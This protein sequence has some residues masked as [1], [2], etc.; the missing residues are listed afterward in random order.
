[1]TRGKRAASLAHHPVTS[2]RNIEGCSC[3]GVRLPG[4][5]PAASLVG[6]ISDD[7]LI[8]R[9]GR[10][11][12]IHLG[13][14]WH[15]VSAAGVVCVLVRPW[16]AR[17]DSATPCRRPLYAR[18][19]GGGT[20]DR[21]AAYQQLFAAQTC[22][23]SASLHRSGLARP[24]SGLGHRRAGKEIM[25]IRHLHGLVALKCSFQV[26][27]ACCQSRNRRRLFSVK[28]SLKGGGGVPAGARNPH[29]PT[30]DGSVT[31]HGAN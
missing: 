19:T 24:D 6:N 26:Q 21:R 15:P 2:F 5:D 16:G 3:V 17:Q 29:Y 23:Q 25:E 28:V 10:V 18:S 4:A 27:F 8:P 20:V 13:C 14:L 7:I 9:W 22:H 30:F 11:C 1:M 31:D 12:R